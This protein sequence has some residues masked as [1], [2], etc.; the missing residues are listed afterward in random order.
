MPSGE[1]VTLLGLLRLVRSISETW[2]VSGPKLHGD[3]TQQSDVPH[4]VVALMRAENE[5]A[6]S[7]ID[8]TGVILLPVWS[9][10]VKFKP[11]LLSKEKTTRLPSLRA[12][13]HKSILHRHGVS[14]EHVLVFSFLA[15]LRVRFPLC[16]M[17]PGGAPDSSDMDTAMGATGD[18][19]G[20]AGGGMCF[21][22]ISGMCI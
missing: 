12:A 15:V 16:M 5:K 3:P 8:P 21:I 19:F 11:L 2:F 13:E 1:T 20:S 6:A 9:A 17:Q 4:V 14:A 7:P 22:S 18:A 10:A